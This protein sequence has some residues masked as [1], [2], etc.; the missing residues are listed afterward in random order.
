MFAYIRGKS[1]LVFFAFRQRKSSEYI[2]NGGSFQCNSS[3]EFILP[4]LYFLDKRLN[5]FV[6]GYMM[7]PGF[8]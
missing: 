4:F 2:I 1:F 5:S 8:G 6:F 3:T 7:W